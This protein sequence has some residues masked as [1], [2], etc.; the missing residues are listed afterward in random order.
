MAAPNEALTAAGRVLL[1]L[2]TEDWGEIFIGCAGGGDSMLTLPVTLE[3]APDAASHQAFDLSVS[4]TSLPCLLK[5]LP[6]LMLFCLAWAT[7]NAASHQ[8]LYPFGSSVTRSLRRMRG[9]LF[10]CGLNL[11]LDIPR[12]ELG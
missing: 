10:P 6:M 12:V 5:R 8:A 11:R 2:D 3:A 1:N 9:Q 4:G 7:P